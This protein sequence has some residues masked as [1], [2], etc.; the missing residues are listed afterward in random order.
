M[1]FDRNVP[2][3]IWPEFPDQAEI[4]SEAKLVPFCFIFLTGTRRSGHS[5]RNRMELTTLVETGTY[6]IIFFM[7]G[8]SFSRMSGYKEYLELICGCLS[9]DIYTKMTRVRIPYRD[10]TYIYGKAH[11]MV[12]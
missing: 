11:V 7:K 4:L 12:V 2:A 1:E 9:Y 6:Y 5:G 10:I 8:S 3:E